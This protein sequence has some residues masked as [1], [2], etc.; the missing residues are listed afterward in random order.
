MNYRKKIIGILFFILSVAVV[1]CNDENKKPAEKDVVAKPQKLQERVSD[2]L[3]KILEYADKNKGSINDSVHLNYVRLDNSF[4]ESKN[5]QTIWSDSG[6]WSPLGDSLFR[7]I[8]DAN[9]Y[10]LFP[11]DY[12]YNSLAFIQ[13]AMADS[14]ARKNAILWTRADILFTDAFFS[15]VKDLKQGRLN[16]DSVTLR[17]DTV[18]TDSFFIQN[19]TSAF[20][21]KNIDS[22]LHLLEPKYAGYDSLKLYAKDFL[23]K[24]KFKPFTYLIYPY[25]DSVAFFKQLQKRFFEIGLIKND[26]TDMDTTEFINVI[27]KYQKE[28]NFKVTGVTSEPLIDKLDNTDWEKFKRIAI[29]LD[30]YKLLP[31]TLP[32]TYV[33]VNLPS[34]FLQVMD[35][36]TVALESKIIVGAPKTRTP[37]LTSDITN[38][39][40]LPQWTVPSSIIFKEMLPKIQQN[41]D[42]LKKENLI[43]V[44]NNDDV[45]DPSKV[46]WK[47]LNK[48]HFPYQLKQQEG[49]NNSLGVIK[50]NFRNKY[51]V[52]LHDTNVRWMFGK[53]FRALSHGCVRVKEWEKMSDFLVR[54]DSVKYKPDTL[55]AWIKRQE[56]HTVSGFKRV[57]IFIRYFTCAGKDGHV[58][59]Y[60]DIYG[61]DKFLREKYFSAKA[62]NE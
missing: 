13:R 30:R 1:A 24:A 2:D 43:V 51:S 49:D 17:K 61:E 23:A 52:Y 37:L 40:T 9:E 32:H 54:N 45:V 22:T 27:K 33:W 6:K 5:Y 46:K 29:T 3:K 42:Y 18:L 19:I 15:L 4:Y 62:V 55:R 53:S 10:G 21:I 38:F 26:S 28:K 25:K 50:F 36:D 59:F 16:Y 8:K 35:N 58:V 7:F 20:E 44:D 12:H 11:Q 39:I 14:F 31:D 56:K 60:D 48:N 41:I 47:K 57:P 34:F